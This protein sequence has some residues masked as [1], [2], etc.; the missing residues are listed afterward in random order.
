[1]S[2]AARRLILWSL[3]LAVAAVL[4]LGIVYADR[5]WLWLLAPPQT[6]E[7]GEPFL[8]K[9]DPALL[10]PME[11]PKAPN[12]AAVRPSGTGLGWPTLLGPHHDGSSPETGLQFDWPE[13]GPP[14]KW[15]VAVGTGYASPVACG[16]RVILLHR[17]GNLEVVECIDAE[18][19]RT[20]WETSWPAT[21]ECPYNHSSGP[22]SAPVLDE[23]HVYALGASGDLYCLR[24]DDGSEVWHRALYED[25][26]VEI[27]VWPASA[28][29]LVEG[30]RVIVNV[31]GRKTGAGVVALDKRSGETLWKATSDGAACSTPRAATIHGRRYVFVWT[32]EALVSLDPD[33]GKVYWRVPFCANHYEAVHGTPP[34]VA[35]DVVLVSGYQIGNLCLR[36]LPDGSCRELWR[37]KRK[38]LDSQYNN[39][40]PLGDRVCG[41][42][43]RRRSLHCLDLETGDL[44][45]RWRSPVRNGSMIAVDGNYLLFGESGRL[46]SLA[47]SEGGAKL[48]SV[49]ERPVLRPICVSYPALHRGLL[50]LRNEEEM[51]CVDLRRADSKERAETASLADF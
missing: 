36:V 49:T 51:V 23:G 25:Y 32:A 47:I 17:K 50:Y 30:D 3:G 31:G 4:L 7:E 5:I 27:E 22:Y 1:M 34:L 38:L 41:F 18:G 42:S 15:R 8:T 21:Y 29:P 13:S 45:W 14:E 19:G 28:S 39:L 26:Q 37:D 9:E 12:R 2:N 44:A 46:A 10:E 16:D 43:T 40:T 11:L 48:R 20:R 6:L 35:G 24:L 33:G